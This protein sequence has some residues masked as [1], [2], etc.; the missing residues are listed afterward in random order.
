MSMCKVFSVLTRLPPPWTLQ[1]PKAPG[2]VTDV[3]CLDFTDINLIP[4]VPKAAARGRYFYLLCA[5]M[6]AFW[7]KNKQTNPFKI[8]KNQKILNKALNQ[9]T[10]QKSPSKPKSQ[11]SCGQSSCHQP[12]VLGPSRS[13]SFVQ[14]TLTD[15]PW[16]Q[17]SGESCILCSQIIYMHFSWYLKRENGRVG[18]SYGSAEC[19]NYAALLKESTLKVTYA[20]ILQDRLFC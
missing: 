16:W 18:L 11:R 10:P 9:T 7:F 14:L 15:L 1:K 6:K 8:T 3:F 5:V 19:D 13:L 12:P 17:F 2:Q 4:R 20:F